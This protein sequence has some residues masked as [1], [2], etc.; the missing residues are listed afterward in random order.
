MQA[1]LNDALDG[2]LRR[3]KIEDAQRKE[4][5]V[6]YPSNDEKPVVFCCDGSLGKTTFYPD[7]V[8]GVERVDFIVRVPVVVLSKVTAKIQLKNL[9]DYYKLASKRYTIIAD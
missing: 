6:F 7:A 9:L 3:I 5:V 2:E 1:V 4:A 8:I